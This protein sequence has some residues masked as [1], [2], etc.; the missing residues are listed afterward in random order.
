MALGF[1]ERERR[2]SG[3]RK[4]TTAGLARG[5]HA[6]RAASARVRRACTREGGAARAGGGLGL[7]AGPGR[8]E[9]EAARG[10]E[11]GGGS[12]PGGGGEA[13]EREGKEREERET[14][15][16]AWPKGGRGFIFKFFFLINFDNCFCCLIIISGALK[17]QVKFEGSF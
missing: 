17:I 13:R 1:P 10:R 5:P 12:G 6:G 4:K 3:R 2:L 14:S 7:A 8:E 16:W 11:G 9:G 15:G